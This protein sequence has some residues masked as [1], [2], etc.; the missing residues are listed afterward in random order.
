[1][2]GGTLQAGN[3][4]SGAAKNFQ[5]RGVLP[6]LVITNTS[7]N[8]TAT[9]STTL[10]NYNNI[11]R[12]I[13]INTGTTFNANNVVF[14][15]NGTTLTN[16]GTLTHNGASSNF[17]WFLTTAPVS[18][19]GTGVVTAPMSNFAMQADLGLTIDPASPGIVANAV[20]LFSGSIINSNKLTIGNGGA[21]TA[22]VQ[23]GN[24]TTPTAAGTFDSAPTFNPGTGGIVFSYLRTTSSRTTGPEV[25]ATRTI[26]SMSRDDNDLTHTLTI[27]GG[28]LTLSST[29]TALTRTNGRII[30]G[31]NTLI[32]SSGTATVSAGAGYVEGNFQKTYTA[33]ASKLFEVGTANGFSPVT[34]N[35]TAGTFPS[36]FTVS[37]TQGPHAA[38]NPSTSV[39]RYWTL[40]EGGDI[41]ADLTFQYLLGDVMGTEANYKVIRTIGGTSVAF[42]LSTVNTVAHTATLTGVSV[43]SDWTVGEISAP[44]AAP[45]TIS[46]QVRSAD[47]TPLPGV[48][49]YLT[50]ARATRTI[51]DAQGKYRFSNVDTDNFYTVTPAIV[52]YRFS[53]SSRS[54]SLLA[55]MTDA[56][57]TGVR[58][59][60]LVGNVIDTPEYFVRQHYLDFLSRE[61]DEAGL[62]FWSDQ[63]LGCGNDFHCV[64]RRTINV[65][66]AYFLSIEFRKTGGLV[67]SLYQASYGRAPLFAEFIPDQ[68]RI[69]RDV[70][71]N[72]A[73]WQAKLAANTEEFLD[74]WVQRPAFRA[75]YDNLTAEAYVDTLLGHTGVEFSDQ[76]R[77]ALINGLNGGTLT[78][79][80]ALRRVA[81]NE[82]FVQAKFN[83]AFVRMQYF[84]YLRRDPDD[85]GLHF[86]LNKLNEFDGNFERAEMVKAF[87]VSGEYRNRFTR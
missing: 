20:R 72:Q 32:L 10:V 28:D 48:V 76:E 75:A 31:A 70:I 12:N 82:R 40:T 16:N 24:T 68:G 74:A 5:L 23:I 46:G 17:V 87:L 27:T 6:N 7:A 39:Q 37:A 8:H 61:P 56:V 15:F 22:V 83:E 18:Y 53:P 67:D 66:A 47:G 58:D 50:G 21:T 30:T 14:L 84:G 38:V 80:Q 52:N 13:T 43:F 73:G 86:W 4:A 36:T 78:R 34:V 41:T 2:T 54:F 11:S 63:I 85:S 59:P 29:G 62:I 79:A 51:T 55:N 45:A 69:A 77:D 49:M 42:P 35:A 44:T 26:T 19:T 60:A 9:M 64:E 65:S 57:F 25:P 71:V 33:A 81:E 3:A 1:V